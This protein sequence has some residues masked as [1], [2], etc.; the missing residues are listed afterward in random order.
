VKFKEHQNSLVVEQVRDLILS[1]LWLWLLAVAQ[2]QSLAGHGYRR[3]KFAFLLAMP[4]A[5]R[6]SRTRD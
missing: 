3:K 4:V 5:Y 1:L 2:V 6:N